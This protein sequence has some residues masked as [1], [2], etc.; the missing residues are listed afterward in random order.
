MRVRL[1]EDSTQ[2]EDPQTRWEKIREVLVLILFCAILAAG[3]FAWGRVYEFNRHEGLQEKI[4][5][6][7][8]KQKDQNG[9]ITALEGR[10]IKK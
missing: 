6:L 3:A 5:N 1:V 4:Y 10:P 9:R 7:E 2:R 8:T